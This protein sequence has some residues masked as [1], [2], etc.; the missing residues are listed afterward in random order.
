[1]MKSTALRILA[2][3][4]AVIMIV[5]TFASCKGNGG[6]EETVTKPPQVEGPGEDDELV[7]FEDFTIDEGEP[8]T[9]AEAPTSGS[10]G[11]GNDKTPTAPNIEPPTGGQSS[12]EDPSR[13]TTEQRLAI[14]RTFGYEYD[15]EQKVFYSTLNPWQRHMGFGDEYDE[16]AQY[17]NMRYTTIK[18]DFKYDGLLWRIQCWKGQYGVL[19]GGE[20]GVYTKDPNDD[21]TTFYECA[22]D[23]NLLEMSFKYYKTTADFNKK[24]PTFERKLQEHWWLTGFQ[25]GY[26]D[27]KNCVM[28]MTLNA[29]DKIMADGI[30]K[31]LLNVKDYNGDPDGFKQYK[32]GVKGTDFYIR[33][34]NTFKIIWLSAGYENYNN[35]GE[36]IPDPVG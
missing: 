36:E 29:R 17:A 34:G 16:M 8:S 23:E 28:E 21:S 32:P 5:C 27:P 4:I 13:L 7:D 2:A 25:F 1:M 18:V 20:M 22:S 26:C 31:G 6:D 15:E 14:L 35:R 24:K 33:N 10:S 19:A 11:G 30:E 9:D 3:L 12:N